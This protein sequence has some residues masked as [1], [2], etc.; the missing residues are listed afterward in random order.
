[1]T[2]P[3][4]EHVDLRSIMRP[5]GYCQV[6]IE[7]PSGHISPWLKLGPCD[8]NQLRSGSCE[9]TGYLKANVVDCDHSSARA[10]VLPLIGLHLERIDYGYVHLSAW[11]DPERHG[12]SKKFRV[13][14][15]G[16]DPENHPDARPCEYCDPPC[17]VIPDGFYVPPHN[18]ELFQRVAGCRV[19]IMMGPVPQVDK[20]Q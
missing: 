3:E 8:L 2:R 13:P 1:M 18:K 11:I 20:E 5:N 15:P 4:I 12:F 10:F 9:L 7:L 17:T 16:Y 14:Q 19:R 6:E